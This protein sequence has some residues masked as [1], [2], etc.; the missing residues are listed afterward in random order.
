MNKALTERFLSIFADEHRRG[1]NTTII[2]NP[3]RTFGNTFSHF[4]EQ[5]GI[6]DE[7]EIEQNRDDMRKPWNVADG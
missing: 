3:N 5:C 6:R 1:Y 7:A 4:Y 2:S